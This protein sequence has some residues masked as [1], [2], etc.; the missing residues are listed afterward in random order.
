MPIQLTIENFE[1]EVL[2]SQLPVLVDFWAAWCGP[3]KMLAP[4]VDQ[5]SEE[6]QGKTVVGKVN[7]DEEPALALQYG[8]MSI[9]TLVLFSGGSAI[10][11]SVGVK[12]KEELQSFIAQAPV[13]E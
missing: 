6:Y 13:T 9:P 10:G 4:V 3:C 2:G 11:K 1:T 12:S 5:L 7:V 8:I